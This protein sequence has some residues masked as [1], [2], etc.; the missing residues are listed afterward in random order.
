VIVLGL[1]G[2]VPAALIELFPVEKQR[3]NS[4]VETEQ[5]ASV[6]GRSARSRTSS[7]GGSAR[8]SVLVLTTIGVIRGTFGQGVVSFLS[9]F[10][11]EVQKYSFGF[12]VGVIMMIAIILGVPGQLIFG[13]FSDR[14][15]MAS[16]AINTL[17]QSLMIILYLYTLSNPIVAASC[18]AL[19][20]FFTY[21]S[22]P[23]FLS[24]VS[25]LVPQESLSL[26]NSIVWGLGILGGNAI[27][28]VVVGLFVGNDLSLL[29]A[30]FLI[31]A[32]IS[33]LSTALVV[34]LPRRSKKETARQE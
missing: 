3:G 13:Y 25:D 32:V 28:P 27:G 9:V 24:A 30:I 16:L 22:Y 33:G 8:T 15:R 18:L 7:I 26:S 29:P 6:D 21:S 11:V 34:L 1:F 17:G 31:L 4:R 5:K 12:G 20:G 14:R 10:V 23:V 2:L 19:F